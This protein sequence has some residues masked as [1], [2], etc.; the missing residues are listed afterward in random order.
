MRNSIIRWTIYLS[1]AFIFGPFAGSLVGSLRAFDGSH[2]ATPLLCTS[3]GTGLLMGLAA[4]G[5]A[6]AVGLVAAR[7]LGAAPGMSAAGLVLAWAAWKTGEVDQLIRTAQSATPLRMLSFEGAIFGFIAV[8]L[9]FA[10]A[11]ISH[12][13]GMDPHHVEGDKKRPALLAGEGRASLMVLPIAFFAAAVAAWFIGISPLKGQAVFAAIAAGVLGAAAG[14][15][16]NIHIPIPML[17]I[18]IAALAIIGPLSGEALASSVPGGPPAVVAT[19]YK[20]ALFPLANISS[21]D[22]IAG[23]LLGIPLGVAWAGSM[24][25][26]KHA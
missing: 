10:I 3:P 25:E 16:A 15:L 22:W 19:A 2:N 13:D 12:H 8:V 26:K 7:L 6:L 20:G 21:L 17:I 23:G 4:C 18:P 1:A 5:I 9:A 14:R 24:I 11:L